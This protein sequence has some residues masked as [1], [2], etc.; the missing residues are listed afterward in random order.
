MGEHVWQPLKLALDQI[1]KNP[2]SYLQGK[3]TV[4]EGQSLVNNR[5]N[6]SRLL[7]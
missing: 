2:K 4:F 3:K 7:V 6:N 1:Q 5:T